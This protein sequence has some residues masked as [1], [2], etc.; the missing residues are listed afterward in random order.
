MVI[1]QDRSKRK[2]SGGRY[3]SKLMSKKIIHKGNEPTHTKVG[4]KKLKTGS[5]RGNKSKTR[6]MYND[7]VNLFDGKTYAKAKISSVSEN[8]ANR[9]YVRRNILTKGTVIDTDKGKAK[10]T[11]RPG[12]EGTVNAVLIK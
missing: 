6:T 3:K 1:I 12:Q 8:T 5:V 4:P 11:N 7:T 2:A 10:I 9:H